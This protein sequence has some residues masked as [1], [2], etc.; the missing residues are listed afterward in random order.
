MTKGTYKWHPVEGI[1]TAP[2]K[3]QRGSGGTTEQLKKVGEAVT[4]SCQ[5]KSDAFFAAGE[6]CNPMVS[7][8]QKQ[9]NQGNHQPPPQCAAAQDSQRSTNRPGDDTPP[10]AFHVPSLARGLKIIN[11]ERKWQ[12][13]LKGTKVSG[14]SHIGAAKSHIKDVNNLHDSNE[15]ECLPSDN[16][17]NAVIPRELELEKEASSSSDEASDVNEPE[18][19]CGEDVDMEGDGFGNVKDQEMDCKET[20]HEPTEDKDDKCK[21]DKHE[22]DEQD[23]NVLKEHHSR[24]G[25]S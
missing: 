23:M 5:K 24:N 1:A 10:P 11:K 6:E 12:A 13:A 16:E 15:L 21:D 8:S 14:R 4:S 22:D 9:T 20:D 2:S 7:E 25:H 18:L 19:E 17:N 3:K